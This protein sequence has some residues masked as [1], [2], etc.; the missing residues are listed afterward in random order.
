[1]ISVFSLQIA[2]PSTYTDRLKVIFS[3]TIDRIHRTKPLVETLERQENKFE[4]YITIG[5]FT[6]RYF[7]DHEKT[8]TAMEAAAIYYSLKHITNVQGYRII[9]LNFA[10]LARLVTDID[11]W[12]AR[13]NMFQLFNRFC[14]NQLHKVCENIDHTCQEMHQQESDSQN[15][16]H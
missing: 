2:V 14:M 7:G 1:M 9:D 16:K 13:I 3:A 12:N 6:R 5:N 15:F 10:T 4:T 8:A 11:A